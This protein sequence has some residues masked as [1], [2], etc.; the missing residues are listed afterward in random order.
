M[1]GSF[2]CSSVGWWLGAFVGTM[3]ACMLSIVGVGVGMY[4]GRRIANDFF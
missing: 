3:T 1:T 2:V 4:I